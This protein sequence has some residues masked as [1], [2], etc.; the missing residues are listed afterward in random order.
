VSRKGGGR[1]ARK[2]L[3]PNVLVQVTLASLGVAREKKD[4]A[5]VLATGRQN[6]E[7][8]LRGGARGRARHDRRSRRRGPGD[9]E[10]LGARTLEGLDLMIDPARRRL[11]AA[12]PLPAANRGPDPR[13]G[14]PAGRS[15]RRPGR[16]PAALR[17]PAGIPAERRHRAWRSVGGREMPC[18]APRHRVTSE[19]TRRGTPD[20]IGAGNPMLK[21]ALIKPYQPAVCN[22]MSPPLGVLYL[23]AS[24]RQQLGERVSVEAIDARLYSLT[25][26]EVCRMVRDADI[27]GLSAENLEARVTKEIATLVKRMDPTKIVAVGGPY[28]HYRAPEVLEGCPDVDWAFDGECDRVFPEAVRRFADGESYDG[29]LGMHYREDGEIVRPLGVDTVPD[30]DALPIPAWD[31]VDF[32]A[33]GEAQSFNVWRKKRLYGSLFTSRGCPYKCAYCHDIFGK[34]FRWR[35]AEHVL[36]E[37]FLLVD[38]Y[39][40]EEFQ[41]V[42]DIFNLHKPRLKKIFE[43]LEQRYGLGR[44]RFCFPNGLRGDILTEDVLETLQRGGTYEITVAIETVTPRLQTLVQKNLDIPKVGRFVDYCYEK[45]ILVRGFFMLG[46]PSE[47][48]RELFST[49]WYA[50]RS[51]L[52]FAAFFSVIPQPET[53]LYD[54]AKK[55]DADALAPV[56]QDDYYQGRSWYELA[57]GFP[58]HYVTTFAVLAFYF[59]SPLRMLRILR[60][61]PMW[62]FGHIGRQFVSFLLRR[63]IAEH[64]GRDRLRR[65]R[66]ELE[67]LLQR[68]DPFVP[69]TRSERPRP[70]PARPARVA[71][72]A[73]PPPAA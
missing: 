58:L 49:V 10:L 43:G 36:Q 3:I 47:T 44:L 31:L 7:R 23:A 16:R 14:R 54:I 60:S 29:I 28:A 9:L 35:S 59:L 38:K 26:E 8:R 1:I 71:A 40:V 48:R 68:R 5:F 55:V 52:S 21:V 51:H 24:L 2:H 34:K 11:V 70:I 65:H 73:S 15:V 37:I 6:P 18:P 13:A 12:G 61:I 27:V 53:P 69:T 66:P 72:A 4:V 33:Y 56:N 20:E 22:G 30:L 64:L 46:F 32:E 41:V 45:G 62:N 17:H 63:D 57:T 25:P 42:D 19:E 50:L 67:Q 39:G